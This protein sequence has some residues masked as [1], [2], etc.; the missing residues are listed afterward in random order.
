MSLLS[1]GLGYLVCEVPLSLSLMWQM[2][3]LGRLSG[4]GAVGVEGEVLGRQRV[5]GWPLGEDQTMRVL[6]VF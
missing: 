3:G 6:R 4:R 2:I 5:T 1:T